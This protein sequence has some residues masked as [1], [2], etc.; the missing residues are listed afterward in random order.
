MKC[1]LQELFATVYTDILPYAVCQLKRELKSYFTL[2][3]G[4]RA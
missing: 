1:F 3:A 4:R 2:T